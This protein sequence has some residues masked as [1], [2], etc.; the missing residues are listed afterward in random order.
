[1]QQQTL[2]AS[3]LSFS[4]RQKGIDVN[5]V[6]PKLYLPGLVIAVG[7]FTPSAESAVLIDTFSKFQ[8]ATN[9][10]SGPVSVPGTSLSNLHRTLTATASSSTATT[11]IVVEKGKLSISNSTDSTGTASIFYSFNPIDFTT[12]A[13]VLLLTTQ[14]SDANY[15]VEMVANSTSMLSFQNLGGVGRHIVSF[16]QFS[17]PLAFKQLHSL[18]LKLRGAQSAWDARFSSLTAGSATVP[19]PSATALLA[20]GVAGIAGVGRRKKA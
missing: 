6:I 16:L 15:E 14:F 2:R 12:F 18:E 4:P 17:D 5:A 9:S 3:Y 13:D 19:E 7:L 20:I 11:E 8:Y 1:M 10:F